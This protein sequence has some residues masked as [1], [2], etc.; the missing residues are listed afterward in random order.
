MMIGEPTPSEG[1]SGG[2]D[3]QLLVE[4][5][6]SIAPPPNPEGLRLLFRSATL[7]ALTVLLICAAL[8][9][10]PLAL[11]QPATASVSVASATPGIPS[12]WSRRGP[13]D[14]ASVAFGQ[15]PPTTGYACGPER[16]PS[17]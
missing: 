5:L 17:S 3:A 11:V 6:D 15:S 14:V 16:A 9:F 2:D 13:A 10:A 1:T 12:G 7:V 8:H 4:R